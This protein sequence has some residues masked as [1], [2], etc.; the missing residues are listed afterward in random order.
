IEIRASP[1]IIKMSP[2]T[3]AKQNLH[4]KILYPKM[5]TSSA[6]FASRASRPNYRL[7]KER[8]R[9]CS[10]KASDITQVPHFLLKMNKF[11]SQDIAIPSLDDSVNSKLAIVLLSKCR[12]EHMNMK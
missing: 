5:M 9:K 10:K 12:M 7:L 6:L 1:T 2:K 3:R 4:L 11:Y 8:M